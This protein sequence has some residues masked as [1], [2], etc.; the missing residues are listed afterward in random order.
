MSRGHIAGVLWP[1]SPEQL[2]RA[3]LRSAVF[4]IRDHVDGAILASRHE[5]SLGPTVVSDVAAL[6]KASDNHDDLAAAIDAA[7]TLS[8]AGP[9]LPGWNEDWVLLERARLATRQLNTLLD[10]AAEALAQGRNRLAIIAAR[11][12]LTLEPLSEEAIETIM[13][14]QYDL[15]D[16][17][18]AADTYR[19]WNA[20]LR[21]ELRIPPSALL[22]YIMNSI[23]ATSESRSGAG[24]IDD[25]DAIS[26][27]GPQ[28]AEVGERSTSMSPTPEHS[29]EKLV[30]PGRTANSRQVRRPG[31]EAMT[32]GGRAAPRT[33]EPNP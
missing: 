4:Q 33:L 3:N 32:N 9:L 16:L 11:A 30:T 7:F 6:R 22:Q 24:S 2:A 8:M 14:A 31:S 13:N 1:D 15:G 10:V 26:L 17:D 12:A 27:A 21:R 23:R 19:R 5:L 25:H 29:S 18:G 20:R 28:S